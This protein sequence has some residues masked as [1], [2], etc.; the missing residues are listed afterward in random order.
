[1]NEGAVQQATL[2]ALGDRSIFVQ[3]YYY[4]CTYC[5]LLF[6]CLLLC[7]ALLRR[8]MIGFLTLLLKE[9]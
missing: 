6:V 9:R 7:F 1:M 5:F 2:R 8:Y 3:T 4:L